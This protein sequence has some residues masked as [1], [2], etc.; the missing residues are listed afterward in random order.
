MSKPFH[1]SASWRKLAKE[2]KTIRCIDCKS[3]F[4]IES[5]HYL[6]QKRFPMMRLWKSNLYYGC[7]KCNGK[8][9]DKI[10]WSFHAI[11]LLVIYSMIKLSIYLSLALIILILCR[12]VYLDITYNGSTISNQ[13]K[14]DTLEYW[15]RLIELLQSEQRS[16]LS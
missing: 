7:S 14:Y 5:A 10:K 13:M 1:Q 2:H 4:E 8:L 9:G 12:F 15:D 6:P 16:R 11:K 3:T